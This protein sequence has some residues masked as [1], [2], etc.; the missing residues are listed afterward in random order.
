MGWG[1]SLDSRLYV[2]AMHAGQTGFKE[3]TNHIGPKVH[4]CV[5]LIGNSSICSCI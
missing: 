5:C 1:A 2:Y 4:Y 3:A